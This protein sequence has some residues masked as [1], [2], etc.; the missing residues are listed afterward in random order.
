M[1]IPEYFWFGTDDNT[2]RN[3]AVCVPCETLRKA[4][5]AHTH[6]RRQSSRHTYTLRLNLKKEQT[7]KYDGTHTERVRYP[8]TRSNLSFDDTLST[9]EDTT[10]TV[11]RET[12]CKDDDQG[13]TA[14]QTAS[15]K[16]TLQVMSA[17]DCLR[18][19]SVVEALT[20][21]AVKERRRALAYENC[22][23]LVA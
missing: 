11:S 14:L 23:D 10:N 9:G 20:V 19:F 6:K 17:M 18:F 7:T 22:K 2:C 21:E 8:S 5:H 13:R 4:T 16:A 15:G 1:S 12:D 3:F